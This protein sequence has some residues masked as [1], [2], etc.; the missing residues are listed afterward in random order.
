MKARLYNLL[1]RPHCAA[2]IARVRELERML[3]SPRARFAVPF[4][5]RGKGHFR[6]IEPKQNPVEIESLYERVCA[7]KP[8]RVLEIGTARGGSLYLWTQAAVADAVIVSVDLPRGRF[9]GG[10]PECRVPFYES[11]AQPNQTLHLMRADSH[12]PQSVERVRA[13]FNNEAIDF[14]FIDGDHTY[15]GVKTD[16]D[17]YAPLVRV[18]GLIAFHDTLPRD[19]EPT[20]QVHRFWGELKQRFECENLIGPP[21]SG[22]TLGIGLLRVPEGGIGT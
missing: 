10:Y 16:F 2:A 15:E 3:P 22:R 9:G 4:V 5:F 11:F 21:G 17:R 18:G 19:D 7:L 13:L 8:R 20:I 1:S 6:K 12:A 14:I